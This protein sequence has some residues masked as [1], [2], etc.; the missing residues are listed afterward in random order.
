MLTFVIHKIAFLCRPVLIS[1]ITAFAVSF[2]LPSFVRASCG[3]YLA[4]H[5]SPFGI[6]HEPGNQEAAVEN[7]DFSIRNSHTNSFPCEGGKCDRAPN[8]DFPPASP[9]T[10]RLSDHHNQWG[11]CDVFQESGK[12]SLGRHP[13]GMTA[14]SRRGHRLRIDRPPCSLYQSPRRTRLG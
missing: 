12:Q 1:G 13:F 9:P 14:S 5:H 8:P 11:T 6:R 2:L 3:D 10:S 7:V 4:G